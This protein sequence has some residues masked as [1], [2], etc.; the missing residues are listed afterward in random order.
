MTRFPL[1]VVTTIRRFALVD[2]GDRVAVALSGGPDSTALLAVL[3]D[4]LHLFDATLAGVVHVHHGLR[5]A[6]ADADLDACRA[7]AES[8]AQPFRVVHV[9]VP[10]EASRRGWSLERTAHAL[11]HRAFRRVAREL[12]AT[13]VAVGHTRDDQ[14]ETVLLRLLR[15]AGTRGMAGMRPR[16]GVVIRPMIEASRATVE[17]F[18]AERGLSYRAD[19]SNADLRIPRNR[20]RHEVLP[21]LIQV[22]GPALPARLARQAE[23]WRRDDEW[24]ETSVRPWVEQAVHHQEDGWVLQ[25]DVLEQAPAALRGRIRLAA[26][27]ALLG[28]RATSRSAEIIERFETLREGQSGWFGRGRRWEVRRVG[29]AIRF[30]PTEA[31]AEAPAEAPEQ[32]TGRAPSGHT[33]WLSLEL[34]IPGTVDASPAL[35]VVMTSSLATRDA[36]PVA[37]D[38]VPR[39]TAMLDADSCGDVLLIRGWRG[40]DR[41]RPIGLAGSQKVQDLFVN[42]K[43]PRAGRSRIPIVTTRDGRIVWVVGL[44]VGE[45]FAVTPSTHRVVTLKATFPGGKA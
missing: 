35:D 15:G 10:G 1:Q 31:S 14:A 26:A 17:Q 23:A 3:R 24:L 5:G 12:E 38:E 11:R 44:V 21:A 43:V 32:A 41:V 19:A 30:S 4:V 6:D 25:M 7:A 29:G 22:A 28:G 27:R 20:V 9:D 36:C 8:M 34:P 18:L 39:D 45:Q 2:P 37:P 33:S 13:R 40:G 16:R 42:R